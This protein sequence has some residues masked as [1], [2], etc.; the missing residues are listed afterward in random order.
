MRIISG[1]Y[2]GRKLVAPKKLSAR[3]TTDM[4]KE[5]LFNV[6][7]NHVTFQNS[8]VLDLFSGTGNIS[9]EF[10]SRGCSSITAIEQDPVAC[11]FISKTIQELG[12][13]GLQVHCTKV[14]RFI[15][16]TT[17]RFDLIFMDPPYAIGVEGY[18]KVI[19]SIFDRGLLV[20]D[21]VLI[22]EHFSKYNLSAIEHFQE[23]RTYSSSAFS[24]FKK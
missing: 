11:S 19:A 6:L 16:S 18:E 24:F 20:E 15:Q 4:A 2:K 8:K 5:G 22:A 17:S 7:N 9:F 3:P 21:G 10:S 23:V 14:D 12:L 1:I 13:E